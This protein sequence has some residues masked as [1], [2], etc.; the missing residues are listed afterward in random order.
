MSQ[1]IDIS[2][3]IIFKTTVT[4][5]MCANDFNNVTSILLHKYC[6]QF[7][8]QSSMKDRNK[9]V[10]LNRRVEIDECTMFSRKIEYEVLCNSSGLLEWLYD[11]AKIKT[12]ICH[13][14]NI[15][16]QKD[17]NINRG[18]RKNRHY[19]KKKLSM[20]LLSCKTGIDL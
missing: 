6:R 15:E 17:G 16:M 13:T 1:I 19:H 12:V 9:L 5:C 20:I 10:C 7:V 8:S 2:F 11:N 14:L 18:K 3:D 4:G